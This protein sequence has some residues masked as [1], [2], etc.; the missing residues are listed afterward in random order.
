[1]DKSEPELP[2]NP[3]TKV[4]I[5]QLHILLF[6]ISPAIWRRMLVRSNC[7]IADLHYSLQIALGWTNSH[8]HQFSLHGR[9][10]GIYQPG[11]I[12]FDDDP[13]K[14]LLS[15]LK[16]RLKERFI[17]QY[18][19]GDN[20]QHQI[21]LEQRLPFDTKKHYPVCISGARK[22]PP[23]DC[24]G[25]TGFMEIEV[26]L[27]LAIWDKKVRLT[28]MMAEIIKG[29][30]KDNGLAII[31]KYRPQIKQL[32]AEIKEAEFDRQAVNQRLKKYALD[33]PSWWEG[34]M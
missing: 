22:V 13:K 4:E 23:E 1:M 17:Y 34:F 3:S 11:G 18:D 30:E 28:Q 6:E 33:D 20:W 29:L 2:L 32:L 7:T 26:S 8:L 25:P 21:R 16:L 27:K 24:G 19:F 5:Y 12:W 15:D 9:Q 31:T 14:V 10:Y